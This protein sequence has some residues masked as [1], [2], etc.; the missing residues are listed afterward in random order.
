M[1]KTDKGQLAENL[2]RN[3]CRTDK[4]WNDILQT[5]HWKSEKF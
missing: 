4:L 3:F 1:Q 5:K 2:F